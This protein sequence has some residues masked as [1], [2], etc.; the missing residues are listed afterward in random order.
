MYYLL[1]TI[2][3]T[4]SIPQSQPYLAMND[5]M[6]NYAFFQLA[7]VE[8]LNELDEGQKRSL[9]EFLLF[10]YLYA[11]PVNEETLYAFS[12]DGQELAHAKTGIKVSSYFEAYYDHYSS[13]EVT[14]HS[15]STI[16]FRQIGGFKQLTLELV[17]SLEGR[18][19]PRL[20]MPNVNG[21]E[22]VV[23][24]LNDANGMLKLYN[25]NI[26]KLWDLIRTALSR[27]GESLY[28]D[29][30]I[31]MLNQNLAVY[32]LF[33]DFSK[34]RTLLQG[35]KDDVLYE[36]RLVNHLFGDTI[37]MQKIMLEQ[38]IDLALYPDVTSLFKEEARGIYL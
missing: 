19:S 22:E 8:A 30:C 34:I 36:E 33:F 37:L 21:W 24:Q 2:N 32:I 25:L 31:R 14:Y 16:S 29:Y 4:M 27:E 12:F 1:F 3:S 26:S 23:E 7:Q 17:Q 38:R 28:G 10:F 6:K 18:L 20:A 13:D 9:R 35:F 11:H 15:C 5:L